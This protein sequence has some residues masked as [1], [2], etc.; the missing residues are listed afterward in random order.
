MP[1]NIYLIEN[2][3]PVELVQELEKYEIKK[4]PLSAAARAKVIKRNGGDYQSSRM[5]SEDIALMQMY[6]PGWG[7]WI[8]KTAIVVGGGFVLGPIPAMVVGGVTAAG[9]K[10]GENLSDDPDD[11]KIFKFIG[12]CGGGVATGGAFGVAAQSAGAVAG[13][14]KFAG[15]GKN[16]EGALNSAIHGIKVGGDIEKAISLLKDAGFTYY[17]AKVHIDHV[18]EGYDYKSWCKVCNA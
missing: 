11:K 6:G 4:S 9:A 18:K 13:F 15:L 10:V 8:A 14:N 1:K 3:K 16:C 2:K 7:E 17:E 5:S 12:D